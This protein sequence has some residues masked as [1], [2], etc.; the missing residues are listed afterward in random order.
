MFPCATT[1]LD[2]KSTD[3]ANITVKLIFEPKLAE[4]TLTA[5]MGLERLHFK[6]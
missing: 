4:E 5:M 6:K 2:D 1:V 3:C